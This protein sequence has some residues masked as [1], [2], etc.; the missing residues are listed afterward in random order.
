MTKALRQACLY[1]V[2]ALGARLTHRRR[3]THVSI[4]PTYRCNLR[5]LY[6]GSPYMKTSEL[7]TAQ[8][9]TIIHELGELGWLVFASASTPA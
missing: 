8:W 7:S 2:Q 1:G 5:C 9:Q 4:Y 6:C 3:L